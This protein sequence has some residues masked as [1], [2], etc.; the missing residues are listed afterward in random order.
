M[1]KVFDGFNEPWKNEEDKMK[2]FLILNGWV[3]SN[4][5]KKTNVLSIQLNI[6][7]QNTQRKEK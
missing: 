3:G 1:E 2:C 6:F 5:G 4:D 7:I